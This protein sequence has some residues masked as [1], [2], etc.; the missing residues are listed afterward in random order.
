VEQNVRFLLHA[1]PLPLAA[2]AS[3]S[4]LAVIHFAPTITSSVSRADRGAPRARLCAANDAAGA[5]RAVGRDERGRT[6]CHAARIDRAP[7]EDSRLRTVDCHAR[8]MSRTDSASRVIRSTPERI[9]AALVDPEALAARLPPS[10]MTGR[11]EWFDARSGGSYRLVLTYAD[12]S[13]ESGKTTYRHSWGGRCG[14]RGRCRPAGS[15]PRLPPTLTD[16]VCRSA[17]FRAGRRLLALRIDEPSVVV[18][19]PGEPRPVRAHGQR[20]RE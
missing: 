3:V 18:R 1:R 8:F 17:V 19:R 2:C 10:G 5:H 7:C 14:R 4:W 20:G 15:P 12:S 16:L 13:S 11:F 6:H 9:F